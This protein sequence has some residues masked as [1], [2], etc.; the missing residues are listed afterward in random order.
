MANG[1]QRVGYADPSDIEKAAQDWT[2]GQRQCRLYNSHPWDD[3]MTFLVRQ[4]RG[5]LTI[6]QHCPRQCSAYRDAVMSEA[7]GLLTKHWQVKYPRPQE[8]VPSYL[9]PSGTGRI[10]QYGRAKIRLMQYSNLK[11]L[12]PEDA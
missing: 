1:K 5:Q 3:G 8:D 12:E 7:T 9:L 4:A 11:V 6:R 10:D 2:D